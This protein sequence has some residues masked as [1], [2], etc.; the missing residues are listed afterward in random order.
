MATDLGT[1]TANVVGVFIFNVLHI[2]GIR[3][4]A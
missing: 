1:P 2:A 4:F 3:L